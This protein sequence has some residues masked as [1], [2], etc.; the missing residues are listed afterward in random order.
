[1]KRFLFFFLVFGLGVGSS[2]QFVRMMKQKENVVVP[3]PKAANTD[4]PIIGDQPENVYVSNKSVLDDPVTCVTLYDLQTNYSNYC[5]VYLYPDGTIG[6]TA[7][8]SNQGGSMVDRGTGYNYFDGTNWGPQPTQRVETIR[9]GFPC[10]QPFGPTGE[11]IIAH[12]AVGP[13]VMNTRT[14]KGTGA[15]TQTVMP[16]LPSGVSGMLWP[17]IVTN[18]TN[19]TNIHII[20][21][22]EPTANGGTVYKG[23]D[24]ALLY[25][26]SPDGGNTWSNWIQP[27]GLDSTNYRGFVGDTYSFAEPNGNTLAFTIGDGFYDQVLMKSTDNGTTWTRTV[28]WHCLYDMGGTSPDFFYCPD[29]TN[30][31][32]LDNTGMAH[33]VFG[34]T[35]DS[36]SFTSYYWHPLIQGIAYWNEHMSQLRQD[37]N[38]D[39][40]FAKGQYVAWVK[41]TNV[42]H[43]PA[44]ESLSYYNAWS[45]TSNP[46]L[47]IDNENKIF[48]VWTG[49]TSLTD[50]IG[51][52]LR[53]IYGRDGVINWNTIDWHNDTLADLTGNSIQQNFA[54]CAFPSVSPTSDGY[55]YILFQEDEYGGSWILN[56]NQQWWCNESPDSN[57]LTLLK[58][59]K[60]V[61]T[62]E[63]EKHE[64][65]TFSVSQNFPNPFN[66]LTT[67]NVY[68]Q[69][70]GDLT[71]TITSVTGQVMINILR[72]DVLPGVCE[73]VIN[74]IQLSPGVYFYTVRQGVQS[75]TK[76]M[77]V[78]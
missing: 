22:T 55:V 52:T 65:P 17:R 16:A 48:L 54:E 2:G 18:G 23:M 39:S 6:A 45:L 74:G 73:F 10:Y 42:F 15:W 36:G 8:W 29:G 13:L 58:W 31:I 56:Y 34:L 32:A 59:E 50:P 72:T 26:N 70:A 49:A 5:R 78:E 44:N 25:C 76:K 35:Q 46:D 47:V 53:H 60:P 40:L 4:L 11:L 66:G 64:K 63:N 24:G 57:Y 14:I 71:L 43:L 9:T 20:A 12:E 30:A 67:V 27:A 38:P 7:T 3:G 62:G 41:D 75:V 51:C 1:M 61:W 33:V 37:L 28:I 21:L 77:V 68:L 69:N 19:H